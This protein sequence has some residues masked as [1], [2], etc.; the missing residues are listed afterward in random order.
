MDASV[1]SNEQKGVL[2]AGV[3]Y[4]LFPIP[5]PFSLFLY[6]QPFR[7]LLL[8]RLL[9]VLNFFR[10]TADC[11]HSF[12]IRSKETLRIMH[13]KNPVLDMIQRIHPRCR[14]FVSIIRFWY[15]FW[16]ETHPNLHCFFSYSNNCQR[17][18]TRLRGGAIIKSCAKVPR[19][20]ESRS[21]VK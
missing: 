15:F 16:K 14:S 4:P 2:I 10:V 8:R 9:C 3:P 1:R 21:D 19:Q 18:D 11:I 12:R 5:L 7:R 13:P 6:P 20:N 17:A